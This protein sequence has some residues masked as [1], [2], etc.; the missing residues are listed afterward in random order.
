M[1]VAVLLRL[2]VPPKHQLT[3][4]GVHGVISQNVKLFR[5]VKFSQALCQ[6]TCSTAVLDFVLE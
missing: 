2:V 1:P 4:K 3:F 5:N 6:D